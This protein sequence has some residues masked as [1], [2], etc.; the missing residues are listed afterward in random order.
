[1]LFPNI[2]NNISVNKRIA[3]IMPKTE[4]TFGINLDRYN[5][6]YKRKTGK[7]EISRLK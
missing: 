5:V 6:K 3:A 2:E 4:R 1:M 7:L